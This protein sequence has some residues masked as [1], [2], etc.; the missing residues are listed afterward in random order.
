[1][2]GMDETLQQ[3]RDKLQQGREWREKLAAEQAEGRLSL[4]EAAALQSEAESVGV[5]MPEAE[6][7]RRDITYARE[8][9][10]KARKVSTSS[11]RGGV[12][13]PSLAELKELYWNAVG[14]HDGADSGQ[15]RPDQRQP[16]L[17]RSAR[18]HHQ[19]KPR[20]RRA[21]EP[22]VNGQV[23]E[24]RGLI[25]G[26]VTGKPGEDRFVTDS[27]GDSFTQDVKTTRTLAAAKISD[28]RDAVLET[29]KHIAQRHGLAKRH[30]D[31]L[32]IGALNSP[33]RSQVDRRV[34]KLRSRRPP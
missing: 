12:A 32:V 6:A 4:K 13:R 24:Q 30:Q 22:N 27:T 31:G 1:M 23:D 34:M 7:L 3:L 2:A 33:V 28:S 8:W 5:T 25:A 19:V 15:R 16:Q 20:S 21:T 9:N 10:D 18:L 29:G 11:T 17:R 14:P 26:R